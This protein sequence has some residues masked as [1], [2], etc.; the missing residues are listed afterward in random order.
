MDADRSTSVFQISFYYLLYPLSFPDAFW[1]SCLTSPSS[2][3]NH[4]SVVMECLILGIKYESAPSG[5]FIPSRESRGMPRTL[6]APGCVPTIP[7]CHSSPHLLP[8]L[9][10]QVPQGA[11]S[12]R[13]PPPQADHS[14]LVHWESTPFLLSFSITSITI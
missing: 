2:S 9:C 11:W 13:T 1:E 3:L 14:P 5:A 8:A 12:P 7:I 10:H 4:S 6:H